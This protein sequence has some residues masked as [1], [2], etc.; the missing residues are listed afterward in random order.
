[1]T[2]IDEQYAVTIIGGGPTVW[3]SQWN[4]PC[5]VVEQQIFRLA[6]PNLFRQV[7]IGEVAL[8]Q[9]LLQRDAD[10]FGLGH[11]VVIVRSMLNILRQSTQMSICNQAGWK[12]SWILPRRHAVATRQAGCGLPGR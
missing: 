1:M 4:I 11:G 10:L 2:Q 6:Q 7:G 3:C 8:F 12:G 9:T 5:V